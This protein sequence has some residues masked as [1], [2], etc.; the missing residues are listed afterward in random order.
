MLI[1]AT[2]VRPAPARAQNSAISSDEITAGTTEGSTEGTT[3]GSSA[4]DHGGNSLSS[5][6]SSQGSSDESSRASTQGTS[7]ASTEA[8]TYE[9]TRQSSETGSSQQ[10]SDATGD[11]SRSSSEGTSNSSE[12]TSRSE[13]FKQNRTLVVVLIAVG[14]VALSVAGGY[15]TAAAESVNAVAAAELESYLRTNHALVAR[16]ISLGEGALLHA[17]LHDLRLL[18]E[19]RAHVERELPGSSEQNE[20]LAALDG[21]LSVER[22]T[23]FA[24]AFH[25]LL[26]RTLPAERVKFLADHALAHF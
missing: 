22:A 17:W 3:Q 23:N 12:A 9:S 2:L 16:D 20:M 24:A 13:S 19:E 5:D 21:T 11:A 18:P 25:G 10:S 8:T 26:A 7:E 1:V 6:E 4:S 15:A 14:A